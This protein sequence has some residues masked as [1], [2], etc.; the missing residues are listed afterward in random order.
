MPYVYHAVPHLMKGTVLYPLNELKDREPALYDAHSTKYEGRKHLMKERIPLLDDCLWNDVLFLTA[1]HPAKFRKAYESAGFALKHP[2]QAFQ[3]EVEDLAASST[4]V[5]MTMA[6]VRPVSHGAVRYHS[7]SHVR[8]L[9]KGTSSR[10]HAS[11]PVSAHSAHSL[12]RPL[13]YDRSHSHRSLGICRSLAK[14]RLEGGFSFNR[15]LT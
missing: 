13:G 11:V 9:A 5:L 12:S 7:S 6:S 14:N 15:I 1:V 10:R 2:F 4:A 8:L 3:F